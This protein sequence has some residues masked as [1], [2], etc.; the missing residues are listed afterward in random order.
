MYKEYWDAVQSMFEHE[1]GQYRL[2]ST[3]WPLPS[4]H[5]RLRAITVWPLPSGHYRLRAITVWPLP[6]VDV[7]LATNKCHWTKGLEFTKALTRTEAV[8][9]FGVT[10]SRDVATTAMDILSSMESLHFRTATSSAAA[11]I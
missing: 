8:A 5:Y 2:A 10:R 9:F 4:G 3:V 7:G 1:A 6:G 11:S